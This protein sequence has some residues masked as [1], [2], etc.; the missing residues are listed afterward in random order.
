MVLCVFLYF[1][2]SLFKAL[3]PMCLSTEFPKTFPHGVILAPAEALMLQFPE[4]ATKVSD[5]QKSYFTNYHGETHHSVPCERILLLMKSCMVHHVALLSFGWC[6]AGLAW[7][8][9]MI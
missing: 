3:S 1:L 9:M 8:Y 7:I 5:G 4:S 2:F 6:L